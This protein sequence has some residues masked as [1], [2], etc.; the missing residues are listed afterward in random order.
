MSWVTNRLSG[1]L[2]ERGLTVETL[3]RQLGLERSRLANILSGSAVPNENLLR[4]LARHFD[5]T[6][7]EWVAQGSRAEVRAR[8][9]EVPADFIKVARRSELSDGTMKI[10]FHGLVVVANAAG[11]LHAFGN[12]CPHAL[13]PIGEGWLEGC[14][15]ECPWHNGQWDITNGK[16]LTPLATADIPVF[17]VRAV[18]DDVEIK[19]TQAVLAQKQPGGG[20]PSST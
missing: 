20:A 1:L 8:G 4:R 18:G 10:V 16:A 2:R 6:E 9:P 5:E 12:I 7:D 11:R 13:G 14:V 15:V 3:A 19:L 17:E